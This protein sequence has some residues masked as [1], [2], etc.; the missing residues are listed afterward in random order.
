MIINQLQLKNFGKFHQK[1][2]NLSE[3]INIIY[4]ANEAGKSTAFHFIQSMLFGLERQRGRAARFDKYSCYEPWFNPGYY[5][6]ILRF[7]TGGKRFRLERNF[8]IGRKAAEFVC[9]DDG[10]LLSLEDGDLEIVLCGLTSS[11]FQNTMAVAQ[12]KEKIDE[13]LWVELQNYLGN[14][15]NT[16]DGAIHVEKALAVLKA[17][18]KKAEQEKQRILEKKEEERQK[19]LFQCS[20]LKNEIDEKMEQYQKEKRNYVN[21]QEERKNRSLLQRIIDWFR[22][23]F[24]KKQTSPEQQ[25]IWN[26]NHLQEEIRD[27]ELFWNNLKEIAE[28]P[29]QPDEREK[30]LNQKIK[31]FVLAGER[32]LSLSNQIYRE[33]SAQL[34]QSISEIFTQI[35]KGRYQGVRM[36]EQYQI[37]VLSQDKLLDIRQ[38][39]TGTVYQI[40]FAVRMAVMNIFFPDE[41]MPILL[42]DAFVF[43]DDERLSEVLEWLDKQQNQIILFTCQKRE[44]EL[45][46]QN[47]LNYNFISLD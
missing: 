5:G 21:Y 32:M 40:Y 1:E 18:K 42:D 14:L 26:L 12:L 35:T 7:C 31:A 15:G 17:K 39:S 19:I 24:R 10:E 45:M 20:Y 38:V 16:R 22:T 13:E 25:Y 3:G 27:K 44:R 30:E 23:L 9:E 28:E 46:N 29:I 43:Y 6:G 33:L 47:H 4:G 37:T 2:I 8:Q 11:V 41:P 34:N 36:D